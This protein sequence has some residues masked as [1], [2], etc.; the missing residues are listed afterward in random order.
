MH[1]LM[2]KLYAEI[3][4]IA[5]PRVFSIWAN[6]SESI[7]PAIIVNLLLPAASLMSKTLLFVCSS[8]FMVNDRLEDITYVVDYVT[9]FPKALSFVTLV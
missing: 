7:K 1:L 6:I 8:T 3:S 5:V 2:N 4:S 9:L